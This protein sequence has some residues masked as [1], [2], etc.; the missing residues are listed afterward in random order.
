MVSIL[1]IICIYIY[2]LLAL[3]FNIA[4]THRNYKIYI[5]YLYPENNT[6]IYNTFNN[7][8]ILDIGCG[9][10]IIH[11]E[12]L[13]HYLLYNTNCIVYGVDLYKLD[14][15]F[16]TSIYQWFYPINYNLTYLNHYIN[17]DASSLPFLKNSVDI[18]FSYW[19]LGTWIQKEWDLLKIFYE[20]HRVLKKNGEIRIYPIYSLNKYNNSFLKNFINCNF[21]YKEVYVKPGL[22]ECVSNCVIPAHT[23]ILTK[24]S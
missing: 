15:N 7:K 3:K 9:N 22:M 16:L 19:L 4:I 10:N 6:D 5:K 13:I 23:W 24:L 12:S 11:S 20:F 17:A 2:I 18:I 14:N 1:D 8:L 21:S